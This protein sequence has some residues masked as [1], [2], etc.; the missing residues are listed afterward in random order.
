ME[1]ESFAPTHRLSPNCTELGL[2]LSWVG[3]SLASST[4]RWAC[5]CLG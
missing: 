4:Q 1:P 3:S 5:C 2:Y